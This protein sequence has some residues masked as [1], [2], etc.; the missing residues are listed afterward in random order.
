MFLFSQ[1]NDLCTIDE[2]TFLENCYVLHKILYSRI[3]CVTKKL[4]ISHLGACGCENRYFNSPYKKYIN[5]SNINNTYTLLAVK[6]LICFNLHGKN[7]SDI[8]YN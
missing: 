7:S 8:T 2:Y 3:V 6:F 1:Y 4:F 5:L